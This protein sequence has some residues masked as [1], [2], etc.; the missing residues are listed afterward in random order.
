MAVELAISF[1]GFITAERQQSCSVG[2]LFPDL[3]IFQ[4]RHDP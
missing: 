3:S 1:R 2:G 4:R